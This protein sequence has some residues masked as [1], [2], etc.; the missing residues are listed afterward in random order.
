M[1]ASMSAS[2]RLWRTFNQ[3]IPSLPLVI[4][5]EPLILPKSITT[6]FGAVINLPR[7]LLQKGFTKKVLLLEN[8]RVKI[9]I[10]VVIRIKNHSH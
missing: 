5:I 6:L 1:V 7:A 3:L 9:R 2:S 4:F 10:I 8:V